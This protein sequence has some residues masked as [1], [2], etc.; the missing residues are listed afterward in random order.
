MKK[1]IK[2]HYQAIVNRGLITQK[3]DL[4][5]FIKKIIE[6]YHESLESIPY[7]P[8]LNDKAIQE[9]IDLIMVI[10]NM[11]QFFDIDIKK[12]ILKNIEVQEKRANEKLK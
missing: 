5:D 8:K 10:T 2:R 3:T 6:E 11:F 7:P 9:F 1:L 4:I 12:E